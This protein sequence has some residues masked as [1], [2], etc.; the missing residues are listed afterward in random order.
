M[1]DNLRGTTSQG[2]VRSA[3]PTARRS[4]GVMVAAAAVAVTAWA[5]GAGL[6]F[7][8]NP[9]PAGVDQRLPFRSP[10]LAGV[11]LALVVAL[12]YS[13]LSRWAWLGDQRWPSG[14]IVCG[15]VLIGWIAVE[16]VFIQELSF[17]QPLCAFLGAALVWSGLR[18]RSLATR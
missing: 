5:G 8:F 14:A 11:A 10:V 4:R 7:G 6:V 13:L 16:L 15:A 18:A 17:L 12:P 2:P 1:T 9:V 3:L